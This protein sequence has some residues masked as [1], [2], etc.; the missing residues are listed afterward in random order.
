MQL[1]VPS[2]ILSRV[3]AY[4]WFGSLVFLPI[5]MALIGP[6]ERVCGLTPTIDGAAILLVIFIGATLTVPSV[7][8]M[9]APNTTNQ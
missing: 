2:E 1:E 4:D 9:R 7:V 8:Q 5:G 3:S 6:I